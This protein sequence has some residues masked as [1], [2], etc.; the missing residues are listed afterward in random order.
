ML[1]FA[2]AAAAQDGIGRKGYVATQL[3]TPSPATL[4]AWKEIAAGR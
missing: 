4:A 3:V 2:R 1:P